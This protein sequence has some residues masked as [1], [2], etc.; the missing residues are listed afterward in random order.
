MSGVF[1]LPPVAR[2]T[3]IAVSA[4]STY[5]QSRIRQDH[6]WR[7]ILKGL[8]A[9][10]GAKVTYPSYRTALRC[11]D[12]YTE[13]ATSCDLRTAELLVR[14]FAEKAGQ[15]MDRACAAPTVSTPR[16]QSIASDRGIVA[17]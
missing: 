6:D 9:E 4:A 13:A 7:D 16:A 12:I 10:H 8:A 1:Q 5:V 2:K 15:Y 14:S 17:A 3:T 11:A